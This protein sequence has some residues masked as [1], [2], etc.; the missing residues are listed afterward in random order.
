MFIIKIHVIFRS[1][2]G[3]DRVFMIR[4][5]RNTRNRIH[6]IIVQN[7]HGFRSGINRFLS[8]RFFSGPGLF[9]SFF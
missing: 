5:N 7:I 6:E 3:L 4:E 2:V 8:D 1:I 9:V